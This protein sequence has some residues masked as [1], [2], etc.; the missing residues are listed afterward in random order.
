MIIRELA[1]LETSETKAGNISS[2]R[3]ALPKLANALFP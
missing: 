3:V 1:N 2:S